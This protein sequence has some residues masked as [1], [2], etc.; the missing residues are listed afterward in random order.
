[1]LK[2]NL[3]ERNYIHNNK[4]GLMTASQDTSYEKRSAITFFSPAS[5]P[6]CHKSKVR[7]TRGVATTSILLLSLR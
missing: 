4:D 7:R 3:T 1:M 6:G 2:Y 5:K